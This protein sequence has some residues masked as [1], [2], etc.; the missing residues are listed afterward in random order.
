MIE[1]ILA[2]INLQPQPVPFSTIKVHFSTTNESTIIRALQKLVEQKKLKK[3]KSGKN[4]RYEI[5]KSQLHIYEYFKKPFF[6]RNQVG[7][8]PEFLE[9]YIPNTTSFFSTEQMDRLCEAIQPISKLQTTDYMSN[10]RG[11]ENM[12]IDISYG[13][14]KLEWNTYSYLETDVLIRYNETATGKT[15]EETQMILNHKE[16]INYIINQKNDIA[17]DKRS[18]FDLHSLLGK[19]LLR[20]NDLGRIRNIP[21]KIGWST[22]SPLDNNFQLLE[23]ADLFFQKLQEIKNPFEQSIFI[24]AFIPYFQLFLDI[25]KRTS[26]LSANISLIKNELPIISLIQIPEQDYITAILS[27]Y[28]LNDTTLLAELYTNNYLLN[29][30]RYIP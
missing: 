12:L 21:V 2:Y 22:Y 3:T 7:Y 19:W 25:N 13:S 14:S 8:N 15:Q 6:Q 9:S 27:V 1:Q 5:I 30:H 28:E 20:D 17:V 29:M 4:T 23:E 11:I 10:R 16:A 18:V 26:R 24:L